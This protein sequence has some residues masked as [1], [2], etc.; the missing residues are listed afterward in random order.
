MVISKII[1]SLISPK[2]FLSGKSVVTVVRVGYSTIYGKTHEGSF[3][4]VGS[5]VSGRRGLSILLRF[6]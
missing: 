3:I 4:T 5:R 6:F 2:F 1:M